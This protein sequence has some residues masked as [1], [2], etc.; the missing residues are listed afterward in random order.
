MDPA[1]VSAMTLIVDRI[2]NLVVLPV[3]INVLR[4]DARSA[5]AIAHCVKAQFIRVNVLTGVMVDRHGAVRDKFSIT[6]KDG[7]VNEPIEFPWQPI[8]PK[9]SPEIPVFNDELDII[10]TSSLRITLRA[11]SISP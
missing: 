9:I 11:F 4:N 2:M 6:K 1:V 8:G 10:L 7:H 3:G 5:L